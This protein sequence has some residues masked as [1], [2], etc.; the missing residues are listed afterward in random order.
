MTLGRFGGAG[1][2]AI[3]ACAAQGTSLAGAAGMWC[4]LEK[5]V[6]AYPTVQSASLNA[7][8]QADARSSLPEELS[9]L[10]P[11]GPDNTVNCDT[12]LCQG[13]VMFLSGLAN[14]Y[15][16]PTFFSCPCIPQ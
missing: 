11:K 4:L 16:L 9:S 2:G 12:G 5:P 6:P 13:E 10:I 7:A 14:P 1:T 8:A 3:S 15:F